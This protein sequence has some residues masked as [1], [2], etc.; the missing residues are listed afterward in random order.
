MLRAAIAALAL[1]GVP[2]PAH[3]TTEVAAAAHPALWVA[4]GERGTAYLFGSI[5]ILPPNVDWRAPPIDEAIR[6]SN[7]FV[8]EIP[9][10]ATTKAR[11]GRLVSEKGELPPGSSLSAM[12]SPEA[13]ADYEYDLA[14]A[15]VAPSELDGKRPWLADLF[16]VVRRMAQENASPGLGVDATLMRRAASDRKE[17]RYLETLDTQITLIVPSDPRLELEEFEADLKEFRNEKDEFGDLVAAWTRGDV[18]AIDVLINGEFSN[19]PEARK[20]LL[21]DR[22]RAWLRKLEAWLREDRTFFVTVGAGHLAGR[23]SLV[24]LLREHGYRVDGP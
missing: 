8:F 13:R 14:L 7:V 15:Q 24:Q 1:A 18:H 10:N 3:A 16:L 5:H 12:L 4:H 6:N 9:N 23:N 22:N 20:A 21:D 17:L 19:H 2:L 11:I